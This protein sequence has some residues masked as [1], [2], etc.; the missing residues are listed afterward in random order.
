MS[1]SDASAAQPSFTAPEGLSNS[2]LT[3]EVTASDGTNTS[4]DTVTITVNADNDAP[5]ADAG[6]LQAVREG[7]LVTLDATGSTHA[8]GPGLTYSWTQT[9]GTPVALSDAGAAQPTFSVPEGASDLALTF[10]VRVSDG[11]HT[12]VDT[13]TISVSPDAPAL[14]AMAATAAEVSSDAG[15]EALAAAPARPADVVV[16]SAVESA[17]EPVELTAAGEATGPVAAASPTSAAVAAT[18]PPEVEADVSLSQL[19]AGPDE[20]ATSNATPPEAAPQASPAAAA[21]AAE[22]STPSAPEVDAE[23]LA[24]EPEASTEDRPWLARAWLGLVT[25]LRGVFGGD[26]GPRPGR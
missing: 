20:A 17:A 1:L 19:L 15:A 6:E 22:A 25:G 4:T 14:D 23:V 21:P 12:S 11:T 7:G 9:G 24:G 13:V 18:E 8:E 3:F 2:T 5:I 16:E 10:E 26:S